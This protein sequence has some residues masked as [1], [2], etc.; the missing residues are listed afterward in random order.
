MSSAEFDRFV[1]GKAFSYARDGR[2]FGVEAY[3]AGH[4]VMWLGA[5]G[6]CLAGSW[7]EKA[8]AICFVYDIDATGIPRVC[9]PIFA[10]GAGLRAEETSGAVV[11]GAPS[12]MP[13]LSDCP[14]PK[15]GA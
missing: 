6:S 8:G 10:Q 9:A 12:A 2:A 3:R 1:T 13:D 4:R 11:I 14:G 5:D 7:F 15:V